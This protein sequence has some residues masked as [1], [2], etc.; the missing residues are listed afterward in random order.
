MM[1]L[2]E[3]SIEMPVADAQAALSAEGFTM[4]DRAAVKGSRFDKEVYVC[5]EPVGAIATLFV[6]DGTVDGRDVQT[7][8]ANARNQHG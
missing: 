5:R 7:L 6:K 4:F 1:Q 2:A 8:I 3:F